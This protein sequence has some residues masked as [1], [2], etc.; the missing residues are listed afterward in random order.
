MLT[1]LAGCI[2]LVMGRKLFWLFVALVG[3]VSGMQAAEHYF[4]P[5]PYWV[6][7]LIGLLAA[8]IGALLAIFLQKV[9]IGIAGLLVGGT[10]AAQLSGMLGLPNLALVN[11]IGGIVGAIL[12][13]WLFD[14]GLIILS[15]FVGAGLIVNALEVSSPLIEVLYLGLTIIGIA[16]Q[17]VQKK[18]KGARPGRHQ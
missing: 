7:L 13:F 2:L 11:F 14:W 9:A 10:I 6:F 4:G 8:I 5:Q 1:G 16:V 18:R 12:L 15:S 17:A 3:M